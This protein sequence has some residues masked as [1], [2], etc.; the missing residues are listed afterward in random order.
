MPVSYCHGVFIYLEVDKEVDVN[1][2][3]NL[4]KNSERLEYKKDNE[5][6]YFQEAYQK[7]KVF[8]GRIKKDLTNPKALSLFCVADNLRVGAAFNAYNIALYLLRR[9]N[10]KN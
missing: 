9:D 2:I 6:L 10:E 8:V 5:I 7:D 4:I 1:K 3:I